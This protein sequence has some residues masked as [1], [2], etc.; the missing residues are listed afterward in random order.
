MAAA[1]DGSILHEL[2]KSVLNYIIQEEFSTCISPI[3]SGDALTMREF[4][5]GELSSDFKVDMSHMY[6]KDSDMY[7][8]NH[9]FGLFGSYCGKDAD[10]IRSLVITEAELATEY[11]ASVCKLA[12]SKYHQDMDSWIHLMKNP[13]VQADEIAL[14]IL[15]IV[16]QRHIMVVTRSLP[17]SMVNTDCLQPVVSLYSHCS[18]HL[19][20]LGNNLYAVLNRKP[21][22]EFNELPLTFSLSIHHRTDHNAENLTLLSTIAEMKERMTPMVSHSN[23]SGHN[24]NNSYESPTTDQNL[25]RISSSATSGCNTPNPNSGCNIV[26]SSGHNTDTYSADMALNANNTP[27]E[28]GSVAEEFVDPNSAETLNEVP[29][30]LE[31]VPTTALSTNINETP[32]SEPTLSEVVPLVTME[33]NQDLPPVVKTTEMNIIN[34]DCH[35]PIKRLSDADILLYTLKLPSP[36]SDSEINI[37]PPEPEKTAPYSMRAR[38]QKRKQITGRSTRNV[39][40]V[41]YKESSSDNEKRPKKSQQVPSRPGSG[42]SLQRQIARSKGKSE[43]PKVVEN[44]AKKPKPTSRSDS[45]SS[46]SGSSGRSSPTTTSESTNDDQNGD[47]V[48]PETAADSKASDSKKAVKKAVFTFTTHGPRRLKPKRC[49]NCKL[50]EFKAKTVRE[51][52]VHYKQMHKLKKCEHCNK[53]FSNPDNLKKH[54]AFHKENKYPCHSCD[55]S[56]EFESKLAEHRIVHSHYGYKKC[57]HGSC[58]KIFKRVSDLTKHVKT[59]S[60]IVHKCDKCTYSNKDIRNLRQHKKKHEPKG[61]YSCSRCG[62]LFRY[63]VQKSRHMLKAC[64]ASKVPKK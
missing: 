16:F 19:L 30:S 11:Y 12:L 47:T 27:I 48:S 24:S 38:P 18:I 15:G 31:P 55:R 26:A 54:S 21:D 44:S 37:E 64:K 46:S 1:N 32:S 43:Q 50:C 53:A 6:L 63:H 29:T 35:V 28:T 23:G 25:R 60:D 10:E 58:K 5:E 41:D 61:S 22:C 49:Y 59:H 13:G 62:T 33:T 17:W 9:V 20:H 34:K 3:T 8:G 2:Y 56:F 42:P 51:L 4:N 14:L 57:T 52:N 45:S 36:L 7:D 39:K 40:S